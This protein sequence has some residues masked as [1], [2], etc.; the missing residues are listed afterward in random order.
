MWI[1][2][3]IYFCNF[4]AFAS[5]HSFIAVL[6][7][8]AG[9]GL[10]SWLLIMMFNCVFVTFLCGILDQEWNLIVT[11]PDIC[12]LSY[13]AINHYISVYPNE[14]LKIETTLPKVGQVCLGTKSRL[15]YCHY[16]SK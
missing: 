10:I 8:P 14:L 15:Y 13:F 5:V 3:V 2:C 6:W 12:R 11:I 16:H 1:I 9:K 7:S 4:L